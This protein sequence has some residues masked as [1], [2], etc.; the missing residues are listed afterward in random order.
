[1]LTQEEECFLDQIATEH[2][3]YTY[4]KWIEAMEQEYGNMESPF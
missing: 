3:E 1:M 2:F 4:L